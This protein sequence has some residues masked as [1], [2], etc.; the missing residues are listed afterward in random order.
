MI[1]KCKLCH[2]IKELKDSH[3]IPSF[4]GKWL[5]KTSATG[6]FIAVDTDDAAERSQDLYKIQLLCI[7]CEGIL[8]KYE[9]YFASN[10]FHPFKNGTLSV[11]ANDE[12]IGKFAISISL[13]ILWVLQN[14]QDTLAIKWAHKLN[15]L[16]EEWR[17]YLLCTNNFVKGVNSHHILFS[18]EQLLAYGLRT[19]PN[20]ILNL[21]RTSVFYIYDKFDK[22]YIFSNMAGIQVISMVDSPELPVSNCTQVYPDQTLGGKDRPGIGWGGYFQNIM[23]FSRWVDDV[24]NGL[25][26]NHKDMIQRAEEKDPARAINSEDAEL[27]HRQKTL[28]EKMKTKHDC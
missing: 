3:V 4:V 2:Q 12:R 18:N 13:R 28:L 26:E 5:K 15:K 20:L 7:D 6:Y 14:S 17:Q 27:I 25:S 9:T 22:P 21:L 1:S 10:V 8:N 16:E 19:T 23:K 11:I 24:R